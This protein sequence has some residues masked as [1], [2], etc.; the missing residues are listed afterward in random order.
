MKF[1]EDFR[2][3]AREALQNNWGKAVGTGLV[4]GLLGAGI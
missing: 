2:R 3:E 4:A 1:A